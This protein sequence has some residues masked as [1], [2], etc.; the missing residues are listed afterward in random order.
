MITCVS[1]TPPPS[2]ELSRLP[3]PRFFGAQWGMGGGNYVLATI[4]HEIVS[5]ASILQ[6]RDLRI[7]GG[8]NSLPLTFPHPLKVPWG[9]LTSILTFHEI[10][11][12]GSGRGGGAKKW[13]DWIWSS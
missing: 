11:L 7:M 1:F 9:Q 2:T 3:R 12:G 6:M 4:F 8:G 5:L 13:R 10:I